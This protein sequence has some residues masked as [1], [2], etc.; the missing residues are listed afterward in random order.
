M[1][2][3]WL[4]DTTVFILNP[5]CSE[6]WAKLTNQA[7]WQVNARAALVTK[8]NFQ[9]SRWNHLAEGCLR[10]GRKGIYLIG[11]LHLL[12]VTGRPLLHGVLTPLLLWVMLFDSSGKAGPGSMVQS[13]GG[14][15][16][17]MEQSL[18]RSEWAGLRG[19]GHCSF[20][21]GA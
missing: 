10:Q 15:E 12:S 3:A 13:T 21:V 18:R 20:V 5:A 8:G 14:T 6:S 2:S 19:Q 7:A 4:R 11:P 16:R 9:S 1:H 17:W